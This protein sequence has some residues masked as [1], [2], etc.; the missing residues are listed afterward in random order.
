[1]KVCSHVHDLVSTGDIDKT[2][3]AFTFVRSTHPAYSDDTTARVT[4]EGI[5]LVAI[6]LGEIRNYNV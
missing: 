5:N 1:M 2:S 6:F 4:D 3:D